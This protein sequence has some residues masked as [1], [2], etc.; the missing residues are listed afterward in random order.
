VIYAYLCLD[1][2]KYPLRN[3]WGSQAALS[4]L[5]Y[6]VLSEPKG[7]TK[8][9]IQS[10]EGQMEM[11]QIRSYMVDCSNAWITGFVV[12]LHGVHLISINSCLGT[13]IACWLQQIIF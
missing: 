13:T 8:V 11:S 4:L 9:K 5:G 3:S 2:A 10:F 1:R 7:S 12:F 6:G